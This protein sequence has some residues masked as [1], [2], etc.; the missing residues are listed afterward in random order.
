MYASRNRSP[1]M[2]IL[3]SIVTCGFY[4]LYW[5]YKMSEEIQDVSSE[6][7]GTTPGIELLLS[8]VTCGLYVFY[9]YY[10]YG[11]KIYVI[12][13]ERNIVPADDNGVLYI[14]LAVFG[15]SV[16]TI[17]IMQSSV[18]KIWDQVIEE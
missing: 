10:K 8:I 9:W 14:I 17:A 6:E 2:V 4:S 11:Q 18:N 13:Q 12:Q 5:I 3:L 16:V 7:E 1:I 15:L